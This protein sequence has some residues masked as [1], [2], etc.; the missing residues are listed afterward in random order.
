[1]EN[2][3]WTV[4]MHISPSGKRYIGITSQTV[5][6]RWRNGNGYKKTVFYNA[7]QKYGWENFEHIILYENVSKDFA[8]IKEQELIK[9]YKTQQKR[10]GYNVAMGG[11]CNMKGYKHSEETRKKIS[12]NTSK[13][14]KGRKLSEE[15]KRKIALSHTGMKLSE[16]AKR[17]KSVFC[18]K[19]IM[20]VETGKIYFNSLEAVK[21]INKKC[22]NF[23]TQCAR[24]NNKT[25]YGYHWRYVC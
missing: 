12:I 7:I 6:Q 9:K 25:A 3:N 4:Y 18:S 15:T 22:A 1:M 13:G 11:Q 21:D 2:K 5:S 24:N 16:E 8:C 17:K 14:Q 23:L 10:Y 20:C 19:K